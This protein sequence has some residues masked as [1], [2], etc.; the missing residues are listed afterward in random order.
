MHALLPPAAQALLDGERALLRSLR[1]LLA[2]LDADEATLER[3]DAVLDGLDAL[4]LVVVVGEFNA[5]K[6]SVLNV[7]FGARLLEEGPIPTTAKITVLRHGEA[8][9]TRQLSEYLVEQQLPA[10]LL[11][12]LTLVDTPGTN[13][14]VRRHQ[15]LTEAFVPRADLVLF[16]TSFDRPLSESERQ[17]LAYLREAWGKRLVFVLNKTD[18]AGSEADLEQVQAY[19]RTSA[20][21]LMG[22]DP[23]LFPVSARLAKAA[24][25]AEGEEAQRLWEASRF[26]ALERFLK[27]TLAGPER[28][29]LKLATP[30]DTAR[31]LLARL[32]ARLAERAR[33]HAE[34]AARLAGV[35]A[36]LDAT[37]A[38]LHD[39]YGRTLTE[40]D[41][42]LLQMERRGVQFL[43]DTIRISRLRLLR[44]RDA[45]K[46]AFTREVIRQQ[47]HE[48]EARLSDGVDALLQ[49]VVAL[50]G[51]MQQ[52]FQAQAQRTGAASS[53][54]YNRA[55]VLAAIRRAADRQLAAYDLNEEARRLLEN[56]RSAAALFVGMEGVAAGLGTIA[57]LLIA[58]TALDVTGGFVAAGAVALLGLFILPRQR[59]QAVQAFRERVEALREELRRA[60]AGQFATATTE[61]VGEVRAT[62]DPLRRLVETE[63]VTLAE[64]RDEAAAL[65]ARHARLGA[66]VERAFGPSA[67][68]R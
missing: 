1:D 59:R 37:E 8:A 66:E 49:Q 56:A 57:A 33:L 22:L 54:T 40:I 24:Q 17:F 5:G 51:W 41:N 21:E 23:L 68:G 62:V 11:Q 32:D 61:A 29:A 15:E 30:L 18:L 7:L 65:R 12:H 6:S 2:R 55:E 43:E 14:I 52:Q 53:F 26:E 60:L 46:E 10:P 36:H 19:L 9:L 45:F 38:A 3:L 31:P 25:A 13:S 27:E 20:R 44:D 63:R 34:D 39:Q 4:F 47:A 35:D 64:A 42:L 28:L 50:W 48:V 67:V 16:V 58:T